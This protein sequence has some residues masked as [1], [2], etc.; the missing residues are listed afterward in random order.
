[1]K[2][3]PST[4]NLP[5]AEG[6]RLSGTAL[7][8]SRTTATH[9]GTL[10]PKI[11]RQLA[12][13]TTQPADDRPEGARDPGQPGPRADGGGAVLGTERGLDE[14]ERTGVSSAAPT[15]WRTRSATS[16][17]GVWASAHSA[18]ATAKAATPTR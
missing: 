6:S 5:V 8:V 10:M 16:C 11:H 12:W 15:P 13:S 17:P 9:S 3:A 1:M 4:S 14:G 7:L 18:E 2:V